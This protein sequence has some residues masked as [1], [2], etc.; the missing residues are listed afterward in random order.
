MFY[1][2]YE[3]AIDRK[4]RIIIPSQFRVALKEYAVERLFVTRGLDGC[5]FL[6][7]EEEWRRQES[8]FKG[9]SFTRSES[10][11]FNRLFFSGAVQAEPDRQGRVLL[12]KILKDFAQIKRDCKFVGV[13]THIEIWAKE[14]WQQFF[15]N[16]QS[17]FEEIAEHLLEG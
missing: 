16:A 17:S 2:E 7:T 9:L 4:G 14:R 1:G 12:P 11:T 3:H 6:F 13:S 10:R 15:E 8:K 5:L